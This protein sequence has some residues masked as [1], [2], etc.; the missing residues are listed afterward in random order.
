MTDEQ[1]D[2]LPQFVQPYANT[3]DYFI[4]MIHTVGLPWVI[5][6]LA[7]TYGI[8][9][10]TKVVNTLETTSQRIE[11]LTEKV[12]AISTEGMPL[13]RTA[14]EA[15]PLLKSIH[16]SQPQKRPGVG[17]VGSPESY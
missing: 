2:K 17:T 1:I 5:I 11:G 7:A 15:T 13:L 8:P 10:T 4:R 12:E 14:A 3:V 6:I 16:N 9:F